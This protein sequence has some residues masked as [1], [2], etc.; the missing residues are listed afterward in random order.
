MLPLEKVSTPDTKTIEELTALLKIGPEK[1][2]KMVFMVGSFINDKT[3]EEEDKLVVAAS[4]GDMDVEESKL[5]NA[6]KAN[7]LRPA[8]PEEIE[9]YGM[10]PGFA[11]PIGA[12][13]G[14]V[15]CVDD[16]VAESNN[17]VAGSR[18]TG[19]PETHHHA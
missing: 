4:R 10:V 9:E 15:L 16:S 19:C 1:T 2:C 6:I 17:L 3:G 11:S 14:F 8:H 13:K 18:R 7:A 12:K 5:S